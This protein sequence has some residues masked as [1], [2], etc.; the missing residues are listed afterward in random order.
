M[1]IFENCQVGKVKLKN[2]II[3]SATHDGLAD[4]DGGPSEELI[5][6]YAFLAQNEVGCIIQ[7]YAIVS[8]EGA[9][10][11]PGCLAFYGDSVADKYKKLTDAVHQYGTPIIAQLA[12]C[13]RQTS[14]KLI[15]VKKIAPSAKRH[16]FYPDKAKAMTVEDILRVEDAFVE[17]IVKAKEYGFDGAQIHLAHGYLLH[18]F[19]SANGNKRKDD[20]G[21]DIY[22]RC[23]IVKEILQK[24]RAKAGDFP[25]WVK[26]SATDKRKKGMR[27]A[28]AI[29]VCKLLK[30]YGVDA[31][32]VSCGSVQ[33]GMNTMRSR[34]M[35]MDAVFKYREPVASMPRF[36]NKFCLAC[37]K[38]I[39][40]LLPQPKPLTMFNYDS[41]MAIKDNVDIDLILVGGVAKLDDMQKAVDSGIGAVS[42]CRPF[43]CE[44]NLAKKLKEGKVAQSRCVM[45]NYCGLVIEKESTKCLLGIIKNK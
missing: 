28:Y 11:Y 8:P 17:A 25:I 9:S 26:L 22:G 31:I 30:E 35:P 12:H 14:S 16:L 7:G 23:K 5:R 21:K 38:L 13:G 40:P 29:E 41:A 20:Y 10:S 34:R 45:C 18:D 33:D 43:I 19:V 42:M 44:P 32:E 36:L 27:I 6:K 15:G 39:N 24:A 37:A 3:R 4:E 1:N 2:R